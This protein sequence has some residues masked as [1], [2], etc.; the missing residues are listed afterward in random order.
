MKFGKS[1]R[2]IVGLAVT[3]VAA[4][5][6]SGCAA[7]GQT[8]TRGESLRLGILQEPLSWN[9][10]QAHVGHALMPYQAV[11]DT[12]ILREPDGKLS[13]MLAT[14]WTYNADNT[15]L[16]VDLRTDVTFS[17]GTKFDAAAVKANLE[18]FKAGNGRQA[19]QVA[20]L[21]SVAV[22]DA[23]TV[24]ITLKAQDPAFVY[25]LSQAAGLMASP[26]AL[27][28]DG[29]K[30]TPVGSGPYVMDKSLST[31]GSQYVFT[32]REGYWNS[33]LQK[34]NKVE[35]KLLADV[36]ARVNAI[37][38]GQVDATLVDP[39]TSAQVTGAG[40]KLSSNQ[41]DWQ[42]LLL[43][44]RNGKLSPALGNV[45][46]RQAIN[47]AL[48]R[49]AMLKQVN[50]DKGS[51]TNQVFGLESG[52]YVDS[53]DKRYPY[54]PAKAKALI[55]EAGYASGVTITMPTFTGM[56]SITPLIVQQLANV[57][58]TVKQ[59]SIP[60]ANVQADIGSGKF[61]MAWFSLFQ[62]EPWVAINQ[63]ISTTALYNPFKTTTPELEKLIQAVQLG[64]DKS[65]ENAK[66]VNEYVTENAWFAPF[67]RVD[68]MYFYNP[69]TIVSVPQVQ[70]AVPS[71]YNYSPAAK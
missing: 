16:T 53:L 5:A 36:T 27:K 12:L 55:A 63:M 61:P 13:P 19:A 38:S 11:Y 20:Q 9:P 57:G 23:D 14:K 40:M 59:E 6:L 2:G 66:K 71:I 30:T 69:K 58:I 17:D 39:K 21:N 8:P 25:Y 45:K 3:L 56:E 34:F 32:A 10:S 67:Y 54:D 1:K 18:S 46:V 22:V 28:T 42:G 26:T 70:Q 50:L 35:M 68:Q 62:G 37:V 4:L 47:H 31:V 51:V 64:G 15:Q 60:I 29:I 65:A 48:D 52:A 24:T 7:G 43:L 44:D 33:K 49:A 41:V